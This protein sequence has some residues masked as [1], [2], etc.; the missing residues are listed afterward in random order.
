M[1]VVSTGTKVM[2]W[3]EINESARE[4]FVAK[5]DPIAKSFL[6][7]RLGEAPKWEDEKHIRSLLRAHPDHVKVAAEELEADDPLILAYSAFDTSG[8]RVRKAAQTADVAIKSIV[9]A[10]EQPLDGE[11]DE[12]DSPPAKRSR[13]ATAFSIDISVNANGISDESLE[14]PISRDIMRDPVLA[15]DGFTYERSVIEHWFARC[16]T[17]PMTGLA[18][19]PDLIPNRA[20]KSIIEERNSN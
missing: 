10:C 1:P 15:M 3:S 17:S 19:R 18:I 14:C 5:H 11:G 6:I 8:G 16:S 2:Y 12:A 7:Q 4:F 13:R 20:L 9:D